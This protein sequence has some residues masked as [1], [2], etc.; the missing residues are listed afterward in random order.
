MKKVFIIILIILLILVGIIITKVMIDKP[1]ETSIDSVDKIKEENLSISKT[2]EI[3]EYIPKNIKEII[4]TNNMSDSTNPTIYKINEKNKME[5]FINLFFDTIWEEKDKTQISNFDGAY[6]EIK[7]IGDFECIFKMQGVGGINSGA[8]IVCIQT[9]DIKKT[10]HIS[11]KIYQ[12]I[13]TFTEQKYYLHKSDLEL[14]TQEK[15]Y[16]AQEKALSGLSEEK[17]QDIQKNIRDIHSRLENELLDAVRLV[18][19]KNSPYW[20]DFTR[21]GGVTDPFTGTKVDNGGRFLYVLEKLE[22][23]KNEIKD[24]ETK[25]D[26]QNTYDTLKEGMNEHNLEKCFEAHEILHDYDYWIINTPVHLEL[27]PADWGGVHTFFGKSSLIK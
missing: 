17:K 18:N 26:L 11:E 27:S 12:E 4:L 5:E 13:L 23:I 20:E 14:P 1:K 2:N 22:K 25:K 21:S 7:L 8:G 15:C 16:K 10:Y 24:K 9:K 3:S 19:D 6:W